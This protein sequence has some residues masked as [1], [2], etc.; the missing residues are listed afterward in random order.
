MPRIAPLVLLIALGAPPSP[1]A[2]SGK[3]RITAVDK[4]VIVCPELAA[5]SR[6]EV[7]Y[8]VQGDS[9]KDSSPVSAIFTRPVVTQGYHPVFPISL[10]KKQS[11]AYVTI[12]GVVAQNGDFIDIKVVS[13]TQKEAEENA[14][15]AARMTKFYPATMDGHPVAFMTRTTI[16]FTKD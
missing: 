12:E 2:Q 7:V 13:S 9:Q 15:K 10:K 3:V 4:P 11:P 6:G 14:L 8:E 16:T 1:Q 5:D